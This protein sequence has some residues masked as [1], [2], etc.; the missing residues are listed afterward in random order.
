MADY[1]PRLMRE[2]REDDVDPFGGELIGLGEPDYRTTD[3]VTLYRN[4]SLQQ[5]AAGGRLPSWIKGSVEDV[6]GPAYAAAE[7]PW[8]N[9]DTTQAFLDTAALPAK[10]AVGMGKGIG[11]LIKQAVTNPTPE[12]A[13]DA[14][15]TVAGLGG[16]LSALGRGVPRG[17]LG[18]NAFSPTQRGLLTK[19][20]DRFPYTSR[21][22]KALAAMP[23]EKMTASQAKGHL[24][25]FPGGVGAD[26][27]R[28]TGVQELL[29]SGQSITRSGL[30]EQA[31]SSPLDIRD[32]VLTRPPRQMGPGGQDR[33]YRQS[34]G[35]QWHEHTLPGG[36]DY[37]E[38]L[39]TL[40]TPKHPMPF[41]KQRELDELAARAETRSQPQMHEQIDWQ[42]EEVRTKLDLDL[43]T[44]RLEKK[45]FDRRMETAT[46]FKDAHFDEPNVMA[47]VRYSTRIIDGDRALFFD[48]LQSDLHQRG[49][50]IGYNK[51]YF[52]L[53]P[54]DGDDKGPVYLLGF[55]EEGQRI[56]YQSDPFVGMSWD[57]KGKAQDFLASRAPGFESTHEV[58]EDYITSRIPDAPY[59]KTWVD[60]VFRRMV[61]QAV[62]TGHDRVSW[63]PGKIQNE[64]YNLSHRGVSEVHYNGSDL[65]VYGK[66]GRVVMEQTGLP[67]G[68]LPRLLGKETAER[69]M[70]QKKRGT[71]RSL[72]GQDLE[73]GGDGMRGFYDGILVNVANKFGKKYGAKV[74]TKPLETRWAVS[75]DGGV[76]ERFDNL[77]EAKEFFSF[78]KKNNARYGRDN[79]RQNTLRLEDST[80]DMDDVWTM[81]ITP[82]MKKA[83]EGGVALSGG[84]FVAS[85]S[86]ERPGG[87][88]DKPL[89]DNARIVGL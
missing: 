22:E 15:L 3:P 27:L 14:A 72:T 18:A 6:I 87:F 54:V 71:L 84:G 1:D 9:P 31:R 2:L 10:A 28:Y 11:H 16:G 40:P 25:K 89:Y 20:F 85:P 23:Q 70:A 77:D 78:T 47:H 13:A 63:T 7:K 75:D 26:E 53:R 74:E 32:T 58:V 62:D 12:T 82:E 49:R 33:Q 43:H 51:P 19:D 35:T 34:G 29:D 44:L 5:A 57:T 79:D 61:K 68:D 59:K 4:R 36:S 52:R 60:L 66:D 55:D 67:E 69:L 24:S 21:L 38:M 86:V 50:R 56:P 37:R 65:K 80:Q 45:L 41:P 17:A 76:L 8:E 83:L 64:R 42:E 88:V 39:L 48:E 73:I 81:K 46:V 30:L